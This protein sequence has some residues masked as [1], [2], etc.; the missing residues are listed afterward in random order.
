M[1][2]T[3]QQI[4]DALRAEDIEGLLALGAPADEYNAEARDIAHAINKLQ[5]S[6]LTEDHLVAVMVIVWAHAFDRSNEEMNLRL[7]VLRR[8]AVQLLQK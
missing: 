6:Q 4:E 1:T 2:I 7:P 3:Q 5:P 8:V